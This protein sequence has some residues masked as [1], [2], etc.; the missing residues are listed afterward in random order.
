MRAARGVKFR[1]VPLRFSG[2]LEEW[3]SFF[4]SGSQRRDSTRLPGKPLRHKHGRQWSEWKPP[5]LG[6]WM[7]HDHERSMLSTSTDSVG[8]VS[9]EAERR[10]RSTSIFGSSPNLWV[11]GV[12]HTV[13]LHQTSYVSTTTYQDPPSVYL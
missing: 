10:G 6:L 8:V 5:E 13:A 11:L 9:L 2:S 4:W 7:S 3:A 1:S 12:E